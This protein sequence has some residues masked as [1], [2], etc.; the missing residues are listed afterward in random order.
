MRE[1][2]SRKKERQGSRAATCLRQGLRPSASAFT[3]AAE[4]CHEGWGG[5]ISGLGPRAGGIGLL[6]VLGGFGV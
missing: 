4:A 1:K 5:W 6:G 2:E 3:A